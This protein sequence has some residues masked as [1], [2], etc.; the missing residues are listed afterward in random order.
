MYRSEYLTNFQIVPGSVLPWKV[1]NFLVGFC[2]EN[3]KIS[4]KL[5]AGSCMEILVQSSLVHGFTYFQAFQVS[6]LPVNQKKIQALTCQVQL[7]KFT[8]YQKDPGIVLPGNFT[9]FLA[10]HDRV[11]LRNFINFQAVQEGYCL[12]N[13]KYSG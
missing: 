3:S 4:R 9:N 8:N 1:G 7:R 10:V 12:L 6:L 11:L 13:Q 5:K 2:F